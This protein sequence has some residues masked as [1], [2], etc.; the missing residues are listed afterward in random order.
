MRKINKTMPE[1]QKQKA[2]NSREYDLT[3]PELPK[4][5]SETNETDTHNRSV[6][7]TCV[8]QTVVKVYVSIKIIISMHR[9]L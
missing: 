5:T 2:T 9:F 6:S 3:T 7:Q 1:K 8:R 4:I